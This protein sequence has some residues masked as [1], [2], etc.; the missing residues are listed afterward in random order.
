ML[1]YTDALSGLMS[2]IVRRVPD[3][4][5]V[6]I[7]RLLVFARRGRAGA[8]GPNATIHCLA[9]PPTEP[10]YYF[11]KDGATGLI[12]RRTPWFVSRWP[13]VSINDTPMTYLISVG[14]PRF[15]EQPAA[16]KRQR[17]FDLPPWVCRLDTVVHEL[18]HVSPDGQGLREMTLPDGSLDERTHPP[19]FFDA[20]ELLVREYLATEPDP[21]VLAIVRDDTDTLVARHGRLLATAFRR[22][23]SYP[24]R[25]TEALAQQPAGPDVPIV[26]LPTSRAQTRYTEAD[27]VNR[28]VTALVVSSSRRAA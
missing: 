22:Y 20:V 21:A 18:F 14:L 1:H 4:S 26:P 9:T 25:Y 12:T 3:L 10:G 13:E 7:D 24:Q 8:C 2:D 17:Y 15:A 16:S 28:D 23:P 19:A 6:P 27:I 11:W 5:H